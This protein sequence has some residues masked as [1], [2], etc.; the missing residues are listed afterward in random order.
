LTSSKAAKACPGIRQVGIWNQMVRGDALTGKRQLAPE[1]FPGTILRQCWFQ[2]G[3]ASPDVD[4]T[5]RASTGLSVFVVVIPL[6]A[7]AQSKDVLLA[8]DAEYNAKWDACE[9]QARRRGTLPGTTGYADFIGNCVRGAPTALSD[10]RAQS[11]RPSRNSTS[12][13]HLQKRLLAQRRNS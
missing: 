5:N 1:R 7:Q 9:A 4:M 12:N 11:K 3:E 2:T 10:A 13:T 6:L 8:P